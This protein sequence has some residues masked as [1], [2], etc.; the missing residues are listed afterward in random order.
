MG[1]VYKNN[2]RTEITFG[3]RI[4]LGQILTDKETSDVKKMLQCFN[5][6]YPDLVVTF[7]TEDMIHWKEILETINYW[8]KRE[9]Y[10]LK[11]YP[12]QEEIVAGIED[13]NKATGY[14]GTIITLAESF[15]KD[16]DEILTWKYAKIYNILYTNYQSFLFKKKLDKEVARKVKN[17]TNKHGRK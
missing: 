2:L 14:M 7:S 9:Q 3:E 5:C 1:A 13:L 17:K 6:L 4:E 16:P 11:Y 10:E 12:T 15:G 8:I